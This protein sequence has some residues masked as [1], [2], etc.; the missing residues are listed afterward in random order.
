VVQGSAAPG[1]S[2]PAV[3]VF[4]LG[5]F[6][7]LVG[8]QAIDDSA[9]RRKT[10][11]Q[12][13]KCLL[14][15]SNRRVTRSEIVKLLWPE[16]DAEAAS[17]NLRSTLHALRRVLEP[18]QASLGVVFSDREHIWLRSDAEVWVDADEFE[19]AVLR[20]WRAPDPLPLLEECTVLYAGH[21]LPDDL[22][23]DWAAERRDALKHYWAELQ[24]R[25]A[26]ELANRGQSDAATLP[27]QRLLQVD[28]CDEHA[29]RQVMQRL[30][31]QGRRAE[32]LRVYQ[33]LVE[34]L[35]EDLG[36]EPSPETVTLQA[37]IV[38]GTTAGPIDKAFRCAYPFPEP[39]ELIGRDAQ[40]AMLERFMADGSSSEKV[41]FVGAPGGTG[42]SAFVGQA[43]KRAQGRG[44]LCL[45]GGCY[46]DRA[47][48]IGPFQ[49]ALVDFSLAQSAVRLRAEFGTI[50]DDLALL[51]PE[52]RYHLQIVDTSPPRTQAA[53]TMRT[54]GAIHACLR[55]LAERESVVLCLDDVHA[56]DEASLQLLH[57]LARQMQRLP[58]LIIATYRTDEVAADHLL[59]QTI[60][61]LRREHLAGQLFLDVLDAASTERLASSL[62]GGPPGPALSEWL[63]AATGGSPLLIEQLTLALLETG[64]LQRI[65]GLWQ[66]QADLSDGTTPAAR[67]AIAHQLRGLSETCQ[68]ALAMGSVLGVR[69]RAD[70]L[71]AALLAS[72]QATPQRNLDEAIGA[73]MVRKTRD[74]YSFRHAFVR[75]A[76]Y[77]NLTA[78]RRMLLHARAANAIEQ[79]YGPDAA[80]HAVELAYHFSRAGASHKV[81]AKALRFG[82]LAGHDERS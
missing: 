46:Q 38:A 1:A 10:A 67:S 28:P 43:L 61:A 19:R 30:A 55:T 79:L 58:L 82:A 17:S 80:A 47:G 15:R 24:M 81:R 75:D 35:T 29:A 7:V 36:L 49:D 51:I 71:V 31:Q 8:G 41:L 5:Q 13:L 66:A 48:A 6:R 2:R 39:G 64:Q 54:F 34:A 62:L 20:A 14:S 25:L 32:A 16:S 23:E 59:A 37:Q 40:L 26:N 4:T 9:W 73:Q 60:A 74:G 22:Y 45:A 12:L 52:L 27:L 72:D 11:R 63:F 76:V 33:R 21:Y 57:Y 56:A 53:D 68:E 69:F 77:G 42:R 3:Q 70:E 18:S 78:P 65:D 50:I 44:V